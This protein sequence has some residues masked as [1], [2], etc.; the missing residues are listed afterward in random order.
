MKKFLLTA[1]LLVAGALAGFSAE[2]SQVIKGSLM[3]SAKWPNNTNRWG[4]YAMPATGG[5]L[6]PLTG[7]ATYDKLDYFA[8]GGAT[9]MNDGYYYICTYAWKNDASGEEQI[10]A[11]QGT[12]FDS[13]TWEPVRYKG[14]TTR[15]G[16]PDLGFL[17]TSMA[18]D[19]TTGK[20]YGS[21][22][23]YDEDDY[24]FAISDPQ[25]FTLQ[26][27]S[28]MEEPWNACAFDNEGNLYAM[29]DN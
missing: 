19:K 29:H 17:T 26:E 5:E 2:Y 21:F 13:N 4:M 15:E 8:N 22:Y 6:V 24:S 18:Y 23:G 3:Y 9:A 28:L 20:I 12:I 7:E 10:T 16:D 11:V 25:E 27:V 14:F 1:L